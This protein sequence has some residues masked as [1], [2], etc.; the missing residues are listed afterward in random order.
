L[1]DQ[2]RALVAEQAAL[3]QRLE[4]RLEA[5]GKAPGA[6][7]VRC[8]RRACSAVRRALA[9]T[10]GSRVPWGLRAQGSGSSAV[11][12][13]LGPSPRLDLPPLQAGQRVRELEQQVEELQRAL[14]T[15]HPNSLAALVHAAKPTPAESGLARGLSQQVDQL[16]DELRGKVRGDGWGG[17]LGVQPRL[18]CCWGPPGVLWSLRCHG[19]GQHRA[20]TGCTA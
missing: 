1:V 5:A 9:C 4:R 14:A 18:A 16:Q 11:Q 10:A 7:K 20:R 17:G 13:P 8:S 6:A 12:S 3:I 15:R 2:D 19:S